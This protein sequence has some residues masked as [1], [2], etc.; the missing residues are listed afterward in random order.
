[1]KN[2][3][4]VFVGGDEYTCVQFFDIDTQTDGVDV[5]NAANNKHLGEIWGV[6]IP[7]VD[8]DVEDTQ[9][10]EATVTEWLKNNI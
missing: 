5:Y 2:T 4:A 9:A 1:M 7:E 10:F 6:T 3:Y 8:A